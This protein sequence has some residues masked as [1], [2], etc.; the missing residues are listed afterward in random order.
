MASEIFIYLLIFVT[1]Y[2]FA[3]IPWGYLIG[4]FNGVDIRL[5]GSGNIGAT[6]ISRVLGKKWG[7][8]CF[9]CD[10][11][12]G[13]LP[14]LVVFFML[15]ADVF[16]DTCGLGM[17]TA[18]L[19][20]VCGHIWSV[21]LNFKGGKGIATSAGVLLALAPLSVL[22]AGLAWVIV[23]YSSRYV[24]LASIAA[25]IVMPL[26][27]IPLSLFKVYVLSSPVIVMLF[28][29]SFIAIWKHVDNIKR[30]FNG[31]ENRFARKSETADRKEEGQ[32]GDK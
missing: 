16:M 26:S 1:V 28:I 8:V 19:A 25:A 9:F 24:S 20:A 5:H 17:V 12:K 6:N 7:R 23:F 21:Y 13:L 10:F 32:G 30:L 22:M 29:I 4:K 15:R 18:G 3:S 31:T 14:V 2:L 27:A 11:F